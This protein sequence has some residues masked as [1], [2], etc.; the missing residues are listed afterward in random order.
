MIEK[1]AKNKQ[2][3]SDPARTDKNTPLHDFASLATAKTDR[4]TFSHRH[5]FVYNTVTQDHA[6]IVQ[7]II[8]KAF[9][10]MHLLPIAY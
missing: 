4:H 1:I 2:Q 8:E 3:N 10:V 6:K 9:A 7:H 5:T